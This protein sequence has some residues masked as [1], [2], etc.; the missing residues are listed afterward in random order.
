ML[1]N[2]RRELIVNIERNK[3]KKGGGGKKGK[4]KNR[5]ILFQR[6]I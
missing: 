3:T 6:K 1:Q 5:D 2:S 4:K